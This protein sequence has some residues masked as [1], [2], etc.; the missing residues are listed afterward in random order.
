[1]GLEIAWF[2]RS[3]PLR[4]RIVAAAAAILLA[5]SSAMGGQQPATRTVML[6]R[7]PDAT[8]A[9]V[10]AGPVP[11]SQRISLT[12]TL[13]PNAAQSSALDHFLTDLTTPSSSSYHRWLTPLQFAAAYGADPD[14]I[15]AASTWLVSQGLSVDAISPSGMRISVSG[16]AS[17]VETAFAT[18]LHTF[19]INGAL[20]HANIVQPSLPAEAAPLFAAID[21]LDNFPG[22]AAT[23][24]SGADARP[25]TTIN[26]QPAQLSL[27][28]LAAMVD[29]NV[30]PV[31]SLDATSSIGASSPS[32]IAGL[33]AL[34][35]Q[36][37]TQGITTVVYGSSASSGFPA[38]FPEVTA[39]AASANAAASSTAFAARPTWQ[40]AT[41][42]PVDGL[43]DTPDIAA[44]SLTGFTQ[45]LASI[46]LQ[47]GGRLG[48]INP[49]LYELAPSLGLFT[50]PDAAPAGTWE[51]ATGLGVID[52]AQFVKAY[53]RGVGTSTLSITSSATAPTH[54]QSFILT[55]T[56]NSTNGGSVPT[57]TVTFT[58][59]QSAFTPSTVSLNGSG[60]AQS[61]S[62]LLPG[63][64]YSITGT[65]SGDA[66]YASTTAVI[67]I[68]VQP[69]AAIFTISAPATVNLG[70][71]V[72]A[73][74]TLT[75]ASG[76]G[77]PSATVIV[78]PSGI[79]SAVPI[80]KTL[81]ATSG[82]AS[83]TFTFTTN[84]ADSV[85]LQA[86]CTSTDPSFTC[87]TPQTATTTVPQATPTI[88]LTVTPSNPSASSPVTLTG[89]VTGIS[90]ISPTNS[91]QFFDG[92]NS[93]GYGSAPT[94]TWTGNLNPG[95]THVL[96]AVY[97]GDS[98]YLKATSNSVNVSVGTAATTT[99]VH[100]SASTISFGQSITLNIAVA[101]NTVVNGTQ[102]T[103][104][105]TFTGAG[106]VTSAP[107]SG[108]SA[109][110]TLNN[111]SVGTYTIGTTYSGDTNY[112]G[113]TGNSVTF[114]ITQA[115]ATITTSLSSTS[116]TTGSSSTLTVTVTL[117]GTAQLP[118][119]STFI[120]TIA[121]LTGATYTGNFA[122][123]TGGNTGT[124]AVNIPAPPAG[125]YQLQVVCG[126]NANFTC[127]PSTIAIS[128]TATT[129]STGTTPT[130]TTLAVTPTAPTAGQSVT[131][132]ATVSAAATAIAANPIAGTV[133][134]YDGTTLLGMGTIALVGGNFVATTTT[135][136]AAG[137]TPHS[138]TATYAGNTIYATS[139][140]AAV[141]VTLSA[142]AAVI[143]LAANVTSTSS[144]TAV[145]FTATITGATSTGVAPTGT[146]S[147]Y[148]AGST[149]TLIGTSNVGTT[150]S[151][152]STAV[153]S[154]STLP[155]GNLTIYATYNGD[156][157]FAKATS[158]GITL[159]LSDYNLVF[160]PQTLTITRGQSGN[161]MGVI[162]P[163]NGFP[164]SV[165][166]G[167]APAPNTDMTCSFSP[168]VITGG[169]ATTL[170]VATFAP[171]SS[172][173]DGG[174]RN[175]LGAAGG[176]ALAALLCCLI[177]GRGRRRMPVL[178]LLLL[179]I[180]LTMNLGCSANNFVSISNVTGGT[181]LGTTL[182]TITT[183]GTN[184]SNTV[185]HNY[186][187]QVT[188]Q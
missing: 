176:A 16:F 94:A 42:L 105:L 116:F 154:T 77:N 111:L 64:T 72:T 28:D 104:T 125:T 1:M 131:L 11:S 153:L 181:P 100:A 90:G 149:P 69:E 137:T 73:T 7:L 117:P 167:C 112:S 76:V 71:S 95:S 85:A 164:G 17:Q 22:D 140:S 118:A 12:L 132:T 120:A 88:A 97:Q 19:Q 27:A 173:L 38:G 2:F 55:V 79:I 20:Y 89:I 187:F 150:G 43:R 46:S 84:E 35:R 152:V 8:P 68:T 47:T 155:A 60:T 13:A 177:P 144:G 3:L 4:A 23:L 62:Y 160:L 134:F 14:Q 44:S 40:F 56:I 99:T 92:T 126:T 102:P 103:G 172:A 157:N 113:S 174:Q 136:F 109:V 66:N 18:T 146:V 142:A 98:N 180:G 106:G 145:V 32:Q 91:V 53:P 81:T 188:V 70:D 78:T 93:L 110:V 83:G 25:R 163:I 121:G 122:I 49:V 6:T 48:N 169:G 41:G 183:A 86:S 119:G 101:T 87:Y 36:A 141:S 15:A 114:T 39:I 96:S 128:S 138:L 186:I 158:D 127:A 33:T 175:S 21:G 151:G 178:L 184:G 26:A 45:A 179:A 168:S 108:G 156:T 30:S 37:A 29:A 135:T 129:T 34:F 124:G 75:S 65:Y 123:N 133:N 148:I 165:V 170:Y 63:G 161:T 107:V 57:G 59:P 139:T 171:R 9:A 82:T 52:T 115:T 166:L 24:A 67:T 80:T 74:V 159:G 50:Q 185:H 143:T 54:G 147:F 182:L 51:P 5:C 58:A 10:D 61:M 130:T 162:T 31:L